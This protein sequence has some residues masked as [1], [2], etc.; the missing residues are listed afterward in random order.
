MFSCSVM[1]DLVTPQTAACQA[2]LSFTISGSLLKL[3]PIESMIPSSQLFLCYLLLLLPSI[4][5]SIRVFFNELA[6]HISWPKCWSFSFSI[7]PSQ[8]YSGLIF[9]RI[10]WFDLLAVQGTLKNLLQHTSLKASILQHSALFMAQL[11]H[12]YMTTGKTISL[13]RWTFFSKTMSLLF[14]MLFR[15][16]IGIK[17]SLS[18]VYVFLHIVE[19]GPECP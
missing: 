2:S 6:L 15:F 17:P 10:G 12:P 14:S 8:E 16:V 19:L 1:S 9:F 13:T 3:M 11:S 18:M 4:V 7:N 5:P